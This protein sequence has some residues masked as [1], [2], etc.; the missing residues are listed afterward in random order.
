MYRQ[1]NINAHFHEPGDPKHRQLI[2]NLDEVHRILGPWID[3]V[4]GEGEEANDRLI[5]Y[6]MAVLV[7]AGTSIGFLREMGI[8]ATDD[9]TLD[10]MM[11]NIRAG[12]ALGERRTRQIVRDT[13]GEEETRQ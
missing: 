2:K 10:A 1:G 4:S 6:T 3:K 13:V 9:E 5:D 8:V 11:H 12:V 7:W